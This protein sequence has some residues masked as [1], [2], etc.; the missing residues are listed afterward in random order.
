MVS[1][2][3]HDICNYKLFAFLILLEEELTKDLADGAFLQ[4]SALNFVLVFAKEKRRPEYLIYQILVFH[5]YFYPK[6]ML[7][8]NNNLKGWKPGTKQSWWRDE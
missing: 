3:V 6:Q 8:W 1:L 7:T 5:H 2:E 4:K